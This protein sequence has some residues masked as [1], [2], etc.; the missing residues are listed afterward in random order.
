[1][2]TIGSNVEAKIGLTAGLDAIQWGLLGVNG[3]APRD[4][5]N[6]VGS[7]RR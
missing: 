2:P 5:T 7:V 1:M 3:E 6:L 4:T